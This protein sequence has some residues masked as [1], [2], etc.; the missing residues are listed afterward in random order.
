MDSIEPYLA[1]RA[2]YGDDFSQEQVAEWYA[3]EKEGYADLG[4]RDAESYRYCYHAWNNF[5]AYRHLPNVSFQ[6]V[7]SYGGAY[8]DELLPIITRMKS[9]TV[10]DTSDAFVRDSVHGVPARYVKPSPEGRLPLL[11]CTFD[12][13]TCFGVLHHIPNVSFVVKE[14][15]R[16]IRPGGYMAIREPI[17]SMGDWRKPRVGLTK[18]ERGIPLHILRNI[19]ETSGLE[20]I[21]SSLCGFP[22]TPR[23]FRVLRPDVYNSR[24]ITWIDSLLC[25][26]FSWNVNYHPHRAIDRL[27]PTATFLI[28]R[29]RGSPTW[30]S[31]SAP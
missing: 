29:K 25:A 30:C 22:L 9:V 1:G 4:A 15:T 11:D 3:D 21:R 6:N 16:T 28:L 19:V 24:A 10:A 20:I 18:R 31:N 5:H 27:R 14:I 8:G 23:L 7:L 17:V 13:V 12:L 2:L 26:A